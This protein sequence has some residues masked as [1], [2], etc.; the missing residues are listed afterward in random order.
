L[1]VW[2]SIPVTLAGAT[3]FGSMGGGGVPLVMLGLAAAFVLGVP[4]AILAGREVAQHRIEPVV[5][6]VALAATALVG[7]EVIAVTVVGAM[8]LAIG[9]ALNRSSRPA[10][11]PTPAHG[12]HSGP[13]GSDREE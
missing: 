3:L 6:L 5:A 2:D 7:V 11:P 1:L 12:V 4:A 9:W 13:H 8:A 10:Q